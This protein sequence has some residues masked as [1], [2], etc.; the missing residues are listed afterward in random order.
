MLEP[1]NLAPR[2]IGHVISLWPN[3]AAKQ[4]QN[5]AA[6]DGLAWIP[7]RA[8]CHWSTNFSVAKSRSRFFFEHSSSHVPK[9][10]SA[11]RTALAHGQAD[12][13]NLIRL[14]VL[15]S[16]HQMA[17]DFFRKEVKDV[18]LITNV[19][20]PASRSYMP[21]AYHAGK[22]WKQGIMLVPPQDY[23]TVSVQSAIRAPLHRSGHRH[24]ACISKRALRHR[25]NIFRHVSWSDFFPIFFNSGASL[26]I[27]YHEANQ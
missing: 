13:N 4:R 7:S 10:H 26:K 9:D 22:S 19:F 21:P 5:A 15:S 20:S 6:P 12:A 2:F 27:L 16:R 3:L 14:N 17:E 1:L 8:V 24:G 18:K 11:V 23:P 25:S